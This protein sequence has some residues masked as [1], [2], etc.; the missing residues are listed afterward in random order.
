MIAGF[1]KM[2]FRSFC[3]ALAAIFSNPAH[4]RRR[5]QKYRAG[6]GV[7]NL[8][9]GRWLGSWVSEVNGH[10]GELK[11][12]LIPNG[13]HSYCASFYATYAKRLRV[14]YDVVLHARVLEGKVRLEGEANLGKL[15][16]GVY[17]YEGEATAKELNCTY[18]CKFDA[19]RFCL[20]AAN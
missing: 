16:G 4:F 9:K 13:P 8:L 3:H 1:S 14:C 2:I 6:G 20:A 10:H 5:W 18:R 12:L 11:C 19:G 17:H 15:G 7:E